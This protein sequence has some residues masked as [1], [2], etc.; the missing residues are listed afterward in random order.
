MLAL[1]TFISS[2]KDWKPP[3]DIIVMKPA[4]KPPQA[5][6]F[7]TFV[8]FLPTLKKTEP[9]QMDNSM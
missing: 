5:A 2:M 6:V 7:I 3:I 8:W 1:F 4:M 9:T